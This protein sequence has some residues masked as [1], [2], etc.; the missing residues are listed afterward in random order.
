LHGAG[1]KA[2]PG[3]RPIVHGR[4]SKYLPSNVLIRYEEGL[5]DP[6]LM[7]QKDEI[8]LLGA[9]IIEIIARLNTG[10]SPFAWRM[11][12][13][14]YETLTGALFSKSPNDLKTAVEELHDAIDRAESEAEI[15]DE[16]ISLFEQR[17]RLVEGERRLEEM[18]AQNI[19]AREMVT[20][21]AALVDVIRRHVTDG[22]TLTAIATEIR[23]LILERGG[24][25]PAKGGYTER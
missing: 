13:A 6:A 5:A 14:A 4:Y 8:A 24:T 21:V 1:N 17:R 10:E 23:L 12:R 11:V 7:Q 22:E 25:M 20:L 19:T 3:G 2:K 16:L 15:W 18:A 9:R